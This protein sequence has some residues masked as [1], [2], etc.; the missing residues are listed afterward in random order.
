MDVITGDIRRG[1]Y[2]PVY[3]LYGE[4]DFLRDIRARELIDAVVDRDLMD[5]NC[6]VFHGPESDISNIGSAIMALPVLSDKRIVIIWDLDSFP[7]DHRKI[8]ALALDKMPD[9][10]VVVL[11]AS[12]I[13]RR[14]SLFKIASK[15]GR[16]VLFRRFYPNQALGWLAGYARSKGAFLDRAAREYLVTVLGTEASQLIGGVEK[17][18][19]YAGIALGGENKITLDHVKAVVQGVPECGI[20][21]FIDAIGDRDIE[22]A[23]ASLNNILVFKESPLRVLYLTARQIRLIIK[24]KTLKEQ[25]MSNMQIAKALG[26]HDFVARKCIAQADNFNFRELENAFNILVQ[27]DIRLKTSGSP[28]H[29]ILERLALQICE[30]L[31]P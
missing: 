22:K 7:E 9:T 31:Y 16:V 21:D 17:A 28:D 24:A 12:E 11:V 8:I 26:V 25:K 15:K 14:T 6:T 19:D 3:L 27:T 30:G 13:D 4:E 20:F 2:K 23:I 18:Y 5:F 1:K 29:I 10:T